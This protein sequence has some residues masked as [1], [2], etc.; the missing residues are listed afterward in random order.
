MIKNG[1]EKVKMFYHR[2]CT[3]ILIENKWPDDWELSVF[4]PIPKIGDTP[5]C[6]NN[7]TISLISLSSKILLKIFAKRL[8]IKLN[9]EISDEQ[10]GFHPGKGTRDYKRVNHKMVHKK[11]YRKVIMCFFASSTTQRCLIQLHTI[12]FGIC[13]RWGFQ[14]T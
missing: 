11:T 6:R 13:I 2:L 14:L 8:A 7:G 12:F 10:A 5:Q 4:V 9:E 3:K 1:G